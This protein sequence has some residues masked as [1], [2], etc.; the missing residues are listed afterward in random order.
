VISS[1]STTWKSRR[2]IRDLLRAAD[3]LFAACPPRSYLFYH[4]RFTFRVIRYLIAI[5][6]AV[7]IHGPR[8]PTK[9]QHPLS[10]KAAYRLERSKDTKIVGL[11]FFGRRDRAS[12]LD[13]YLKNCLV[14]SGGWL[15]EVVWGVNTSDTDDLA[16]LDPATAYNLCLSQSGA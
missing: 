7:L 15:D 16:Y 1:Y 5:A 10:N 8:L 4:F 9:P 3:Q 13:R 14:S 12:I 6:A 11:I 2:P